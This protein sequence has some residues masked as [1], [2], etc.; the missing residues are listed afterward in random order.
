MMHS[1]DRYPYQD[2]HL[3]C[4]PGGGHCAAVLEGLV[5][6]FQLVGFV[7]LVSLVLLIA[8]LFWER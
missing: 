8:G 6:L 7:W 3:D 2:M 4:C 5:G 1:R